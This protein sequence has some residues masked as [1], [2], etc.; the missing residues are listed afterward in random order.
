MT[1]ARRLRVTRVRAGISARHLS[2]LAG[3]APGHVAQIELGKGQKSV[4]LET[5]M[6]LAEALGVRLD[7]LA[8]GLAPQSRR[9]SA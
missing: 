8:S 1:F 5:G 4:S 6:A 2:E 9:A 7:W 3:L